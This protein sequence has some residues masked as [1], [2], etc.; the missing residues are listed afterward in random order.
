MKKEFF[1]ST[2]ACV[3]IVFV[4]YDAAVCGG[5]NSPRKEI[6]AAAP[7]A[8]SRNRGNSN[9][10][11]EINDKYTIAHHV[12]ADTTIQTFDGHVN[13]PKVYSFNQY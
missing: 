11:E 4:F 3:H 12:C 5:T 2:A 9:R 8:L 1:A 10:M 13:P 7:H 6:N